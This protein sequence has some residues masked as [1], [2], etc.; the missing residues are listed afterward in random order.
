MNKSLVD[1]FL[2]FTQLQMTA[3]NRESMS[4]IDFFYFYLDF[5][6]RTAVVRFNQTR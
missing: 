4:S 1:I 6:S 5:M 2:H 3:K